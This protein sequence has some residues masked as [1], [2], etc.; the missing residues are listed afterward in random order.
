MS[1]T[2]ATDTPTPVHLEWPLRLVDQS[3]GSVGFA[4][5]E[6]HSPQEFLRGLA[7][8]CEV[9][10][11]ELPWDDEFGIPDPIGTTDPDG[12]AMEIEA[13]LGEIDPRFPASVIVTEREA[14]G[15]Q[16]GLAILGTGGEVL[17]ATEVNVDA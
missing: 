12:T 5:V 14:G 7:L 3:D 15:R 4:T 8:A 16:I 9:R 13:A 2:D 1:F 6:Q 11:D 17:D 10:A